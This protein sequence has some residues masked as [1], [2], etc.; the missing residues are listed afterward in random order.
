MLRLV[1]ANPRKIALTA[2]DECY[3]RVEAAGIEPA[4]RDISTMASTCVADAL[5]FARKADH[6]QPESQTS[7]ERVLTASVLDMTC[8]DLELVTSFQ[9]SPAKPISRGFV[10]LRSQCERVI[11]G[12]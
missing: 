5:N 12:N 3:L 6:R 2:Y 9:G 7:R 10:L 1:A 4:S 8:G 11:F